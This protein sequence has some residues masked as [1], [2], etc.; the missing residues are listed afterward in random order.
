VR[1]RLDHG[2]LRGLAHA[3]REVV[4]MID[5]PIR[6][7]DWATLPTVT[8]ALEIAP[9]RAMR[10]FRTVDGAMAGQFEAMIEAFGTGA[11]LVADLVLTATRD[12]T[13]NRAGFIV[14]H[15]L[16]GVAGAPLTVRHADG[17]EEALRFPALISPGQPVMDIAALSHRVGDVE[18]TIAFEGEVFEM[19]DQR[20]WTDAS[21]KT[22]CRPLALPRPYLLRAGDEVRQRIVVTLHRVGQSVAVAADPRPEAA[23]MPAICLAHEAA[24]TGAPHPD[25]AALAPQGVLLR[26]VGGAAAGAE[27]LPD[28][29]VTL[30][31]VT[32]PDPQADLRA[33]Q[34]AIAAPARVVA[35]PRGYLASHQPEG[36][37]PEGRRPWTFSPSSAPRSRGPRPGAGC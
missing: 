5:Y 1:A 21:F 31:I 6:D 37:W 14:L 33:A 25:L 27:G 18:V 23:R 7:A 9:N 32:G 2:A 24:I 12:I 36:P 11:R 17:L 16:D 4:R 19:E 15:P 8:E 29:P 34:A 13:V 3:G 28:C 30:E 35:L 22:Y 10:R 20:N 26:M